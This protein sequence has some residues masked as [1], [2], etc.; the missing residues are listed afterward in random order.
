MLGS[1]M[2]TMTIGCGLRGKQTAILGKGLT[3]ILPASLMIVDTSCMASRRCIHAGLVNRPS[4][5]SV[6]LSEMSV[7]TA[8]SSEGAK[9]IG[10]VSSSPGLAWSSA[11]GLPAAAEQSVRSADHDRLCDPLQTYSPMCTTP[12]W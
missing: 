6:S 1:L 4:S 8:A 9:P 5:L 7:R 3:E 12:K 11:A 10:A 2:M